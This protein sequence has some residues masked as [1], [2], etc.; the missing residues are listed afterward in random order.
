MLGKSSHF[1]S[2]TGQK[3]LESCL[4]SPNHIRACWIKKMLASLIVQNLPNE[5][6][7]VFHYRCPNKCL[8]STGYFFLDFDVQC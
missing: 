1:A 4:K 2:S 6:P 8:E 7:C 5:T 3:S